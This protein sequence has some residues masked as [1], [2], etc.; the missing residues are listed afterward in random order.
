[1]LITPEYV[2]EQKRLHTMGTGAYG[3]RGFNWAYLILGIAEIE[4][5]N[6]ILDYGCGKGS[7]G[8][9]LK[10]VKKE[11]Q[12]YD[13]GV[14]AFSASPKPA[15]LVVSLDMMEHVEPEC[16]ASVL[17]HI[18]DLTKKILFVAIS[19]R[20]A[21]RFLTDGR[22]AHLIV[23]LD[24]WWREKFEFVGF[25]CRRVWQTGIPEWVAMLEKKS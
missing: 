4:K 11:V 7:L 15:D 23:Q 9:A 16:L 8:R 17:D 12:S 2:E 25:N 13:P 21:K 18:R 10:N 3:D 5:C 20:P 14:Q 6:S 22:N 24:V 19:T 1:M